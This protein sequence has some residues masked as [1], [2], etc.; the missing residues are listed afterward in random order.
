MGPVM[1]CQ[2]QWKEDNVHNLQSF[3]QTAANAPETE[4]ANTTSGRY[5]YILWR[6]P[7]SRTYLE[8]P[9]PEEPGQSKDQASFDEEA[10]MHRMGR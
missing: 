10:V 9:A 1:A 5:T 3:Q 7:G 8:N 6:H 4:W 2:S